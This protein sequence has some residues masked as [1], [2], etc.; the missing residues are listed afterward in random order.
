MVLG[1]RSN[2]NGEPAIS[3]QERFVNCF[4][5][6]RARK[7][8]LAGPALSPLAGMVRLN[9]YT[10]PESILPHYSGIAQ[11]STESSISTAREKN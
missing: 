10:L 6:H 11:A 3:M 7:Y 4:S 5:G 9:S 2:H 8:F 1:K